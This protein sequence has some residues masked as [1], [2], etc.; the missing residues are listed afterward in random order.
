MSDVNVNVN[1]P[2]SNPMSDV[3]VNMPCLSDLIYV[4][5]FME[6]ADRPP[7]GTDSLEGYVANFLKMAETQIPIV[8]Y[9]CPL[10]YDIFGAR[11]AAYSNVECMALDENYGFAGG[12]NRCFAD[13]TDDASEFIFLKVNIAL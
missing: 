12:Y 3:D 6:V 9:I 8:L 5:A 10:Y 7:L 4:S 13:L 11:L 1:N 2:M